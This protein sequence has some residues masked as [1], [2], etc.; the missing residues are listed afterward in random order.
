MGK[1]HSIG[2]LGGTFD[3]IHFGHLLTAEAVREI[4]SLN[5]I[6]FIP[7]AVPPH[8]L[9]KEIAAAKHR[10]SMA[11]LAT[12]GN[13]FFCVSDMELQRKGPSYTTDTIDA[14]K[15]EQ[16]A[17]TEIYF[18]TGADAINA[19]DT[20][21]APTELLAKCHFVAATRQGTSLARDF[22]REC[23]GELAQEHIHEVE[24][25]ELE[26]SS[27]EIRRRIQE[28]LSIRYMVPE[29]VAEYIFKEGLYL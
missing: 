22:L 16:G 6:I 24:T 7:A 5:K 27:T 17:D 19:L 25:P 4:L 2:V 21:R 3:P 23:F 29:S 10:L 13:P 9:G 15:R 14:L 26:I 1:C 18:I 8:K 20:W 11:V 12:Q 28:G